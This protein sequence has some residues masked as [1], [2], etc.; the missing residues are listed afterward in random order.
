[1]DTLLLIYLIISLHTEILKP[2]E[3]HYSHGFSNAK[4]IHH[5]ATLAEVD[6]VL[7]NFSARKPTRRVVLCQYFSARA[8][9]GQ[10]WVHEF[11]QAPDN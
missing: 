11:V 6:M 5:A 10:P 3:A 8:R 1:M 2:S 7:S 9:H 4:T